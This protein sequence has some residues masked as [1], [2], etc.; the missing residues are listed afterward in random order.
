MSQVERTIEVSV[1]VGTAYNQWTQFEEFPKF[2]EGV[3]SV[4]QLDD[5][6]L[7]WKAEVGGRDKEWQAEIQE[8][9]P[10]KHIIWRSTDGSTNAGIVRFEP[11]DTTTTR[12]AL[13]MSYDPEGFAESI[14]DALGFMERRIA[15][16]LVRFK[17]FI[18]DRGTETGGYRETLE[19]PSVPGGHTR[20]R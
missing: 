4:R 18:E 1:P 11:L 2:M 16:D 19:N 5:R 6:H 10:D 17:E 7:E 9:V 12:V 3:H 13:Q 8:Q 20:G 14:G 15:G